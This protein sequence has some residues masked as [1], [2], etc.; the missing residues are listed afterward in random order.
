MQLANAYRGITPYVSD[1]PLP[2]EL[3]DEFQHGL[4]GH[5]LRAYHATRLLPHEVEMIREQ[6]LRLLTEELVLD[7]VDAAWRHS[8]VSDE[9]AEVLRSSHVFA[10]RGQAWNRANQICLLLSTNSM[11][12]RGKGIQWLLRTWG[13]EAVQMSSGHEHLSERVNQLGNPAIVV[14]DL[15]LN[16][17]EKHALF[18]G[19]HKAFVGRMIGLEGID[20]DI[21]YRS[22]IPPDRIAAIW[23]PGDPEY[24]RYAGLPAG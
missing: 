14:A 16:D 15:D 2:F 23:Q 21:F 8:F 6:G 9:E 5:L 20:A 1:L 10:H 11:E 4:A 17:G 24:D 18:P 12:N 19:L 3:E 13:G 7:R 22:P